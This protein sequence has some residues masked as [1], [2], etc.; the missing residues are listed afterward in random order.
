MSL[1][2]G[3]HTLTGCSVVKS[4]TGVEARR[5]V[6]SRL[7]DPVDDVGVD[8]DVVR[9]GSEGGVQVVRPVLVEPRPGVEID[10][11]GA[12]RAVES[13]GGLDEGRRDALSLEEL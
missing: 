1:F 2:Q 4:S 5:R 10:D 6:A 3:C 13:G 8:V 12:V 7:F 9:G 11:L